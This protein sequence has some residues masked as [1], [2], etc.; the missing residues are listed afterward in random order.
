MR[1]GR[2]REH[3]GGSSETAP[4]TGPSASF[5][6]IS[7]SYRAEDGQS[8]I[9]ALYHAREAARSS[10]AQLR[11]RKRADADLWGKAG[12]GHNLF[13]ADILMGWRNNRNS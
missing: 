5:C 8:H 13:R 11:L 12:A 6:G 9:P 10:Q 3:P 4:C 7:M 2:E 1:G